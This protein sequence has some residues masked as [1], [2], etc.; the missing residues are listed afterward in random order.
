MGARGSGICL[1]ASARATTDSP[2]TH[3][4]ATNG[5]SDGGYVGDEGPRQRKTDA[6]F[7]ME[8]FDIRKP[9]DRQE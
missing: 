7:A 6:G 2:E 1:F 9:E 5:N 4:A 3:E 8:Y